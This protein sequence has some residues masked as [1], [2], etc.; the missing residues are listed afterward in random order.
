MVSSVKPAKYATSSSV[1]VNAT[2]P[3]SSAHAKVYSSAAASSSAV[4]SHVLASSSAVAYP[5]HEAGYKRE[6]YYGATPT[7][8]KVYAAPTSSKA[9]AAPVESEAAAVD[10]SKSAGS[11]DPHQIVFN[12]LARVRSPY[13]YTY[14]DSD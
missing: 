12:F 5:S 2:L 4:Y 6:E 10:S 8:S 7:S 1:V 13:L 9:W 3:S 14:V 11:L